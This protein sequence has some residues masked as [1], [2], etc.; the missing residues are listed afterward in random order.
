MT[1]WKKGERVERSIQRIY[2]IIYYTEYTSNKYKNIIILY[3][4]CYIV[5]TGLL[6]IY[7]RYIDNRRI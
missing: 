3:Y 4:S 1:S 6:Y 2:I 5:K 7:V